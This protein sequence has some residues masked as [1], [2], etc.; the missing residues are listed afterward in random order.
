VDVYIHFPIRLHSI[1][2][3]YISRGT[4]LPLRVIELFLGLEGV[5]LRGRQRG[6]DVGHL[7]EVTKMADVIKE[8]QDRRR[9]V[10]PGYQPVDY[11]KVFSV[12]P[13]GTCYSRRPRVRCVTS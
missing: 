7:F 4:A 2:L 1:V 13:R 8:C 5:A 6:E 9:I 10:L 3:N 11:Q 12:K